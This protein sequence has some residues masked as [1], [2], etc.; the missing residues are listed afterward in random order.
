MTARDMHQ[1]NVGKEL[2]A[3]EGLTVRQLPSNAF[4][5]ASLKADMTFQRMT[6]VA[7]LT[8]A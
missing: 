3:L 8:V 5:S 4:G 7:G 2:A 1:V 6:Y